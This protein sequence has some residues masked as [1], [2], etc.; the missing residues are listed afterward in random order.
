[1]SS[2]TLYESRLEPGG[3]VHTPLCDSRLEGSGKRET[4]EE[5]EP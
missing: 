1:V 5:K 2:F 3:A 4:R